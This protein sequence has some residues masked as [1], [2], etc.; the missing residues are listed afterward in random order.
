MNDPACDR[1]GAYLASSGECVVCPGVEYT[2]EQA[3]DLL[4]RALTNQMYGDPDHH[5]PDV[6]RDVEVWC[7]V[8]GP[9]K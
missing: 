7:R 2:L 3:H 1:C 4:D 9:P 5:D 8:A 6:W